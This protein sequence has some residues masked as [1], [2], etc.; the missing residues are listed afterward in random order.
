MEICAHDN[1]H[2]GRGDDGKEQKQHGHPVLFIG[3]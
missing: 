2:S 1:G 3:E